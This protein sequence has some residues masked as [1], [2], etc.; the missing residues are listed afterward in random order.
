MNERLGTHA[1]GIIDVIGNEQT[2]VRVVT[3]A[4][5]TAFLVPCEKNQIGQHFVAKNP[6]P[7][8]NSIGPVN[9]WFAFDGGLCFNFHFQFLDEFKELPAFPRRQCLYL[10]QNF[11]RAHQTQCTPDWTFRASSPKGKKIARSFLE[12]AII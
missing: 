7:P 3:H 11:I 1:V 2:G 12:L 8:G 4:A 9:P 5:S 6:T 10:L